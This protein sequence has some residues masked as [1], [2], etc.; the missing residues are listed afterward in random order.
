[1][2]IIWQEALRVTIP[3]QPVPKGR[4]RFYMRGKHLKVHTDAKTKAFEN[5]VAMIIGTDPALRGQPRPLCGVRSPVRVDIQAIFQRPASMM[6]KADSDELV[7]HAKRPDLDNVVKAV[8]DGIQAAGGLIWK[9]D[10]QVQC[11][12]AESWYAEKWE[13]ARTELVVFRAVEVQP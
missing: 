9:D 2:S 1:M 3:G 11:L 10:G 8:L 13:P 6:R 5:K 7:P 4:P 12:R